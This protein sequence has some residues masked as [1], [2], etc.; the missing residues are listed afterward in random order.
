[1]AGA[2]T[3]GLTSCNDTKSY[4]DYVNEERHYIQ[5]WLDYQGFEVTAKF[6]EEEIENIAKAILEDSIPPSEFIELGKWYQITEGDFKRLCFRVNSWGDGY[7][8]MKSKKKFYEDDNVLVRYE[9]LNCLTDYDYSDDAKNI[10]GD[11]LDP[12]SYEICY[13][14]RRNYYSN[15]Y[16][17]YSYSTG[18]SYECDSGGL[19]FPIR[20]LWQGGEAS[21]IVPFNI[22]S[23]KF[24]NYYYTLYYG[25]VR[26]TKPNYLPQ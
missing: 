23:S 25:T 26:Y 12:N 20:F 5:Q 7:P 19:A 21:V 17:A 24:S 2:L 4:A 6:D 9:D 10:I 15:T 13:S 1:M 22:V 8:D 14:W 16:Y 11:N 18:S 3:L